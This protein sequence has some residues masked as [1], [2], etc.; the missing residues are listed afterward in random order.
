MEVC[1]P[2]GARPS[3]VVHEWPKGNPWGDGC[4][5]EQVKDVVQQALAEAGGAHKSDLTLPDFE[6]ALKR[7]DLSGMKV[8]RPTA[9]RA[10]LADR[11]K[12]APRMFSNCFLLR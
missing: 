3:A 12:E 2:A 8:R 10:P 4:S 9:A 7:A 6:K 5:E 1:L 11:I